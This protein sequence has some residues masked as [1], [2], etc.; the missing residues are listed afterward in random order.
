MYFLLLYN[1]FKI[2]LA[3]CSPLYILAHISAT[4]L[5]KEKKKEKTDNACEGHMEIL[6]LRTD[7]AIFDLYESKQNSAC[8]LQGMPKVSPTP[9]V[10]EVS[11]VAL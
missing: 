10:I 9:N 1:D 3:G 4:I 8:S 5:S 11:L 6:I 2:L 7:S